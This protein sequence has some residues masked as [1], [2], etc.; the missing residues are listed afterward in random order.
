MYSLDTGSAKKDSAIDGFKYGPD[1][2]KRLTAGL[3]DHKEHLARVKQQVTIREQIRWFI[4][5]KDHGMIKMTPK[6]Q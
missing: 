4:K 1:V 6:M 2:Y 5:L 3:N